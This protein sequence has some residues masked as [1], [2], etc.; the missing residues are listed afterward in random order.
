MRRTLLHG[1]LLAALGLVAVACNAIVGITDVRLRADAGKA[2]ADGG[3]EDPDAAID[4]DSGQPVVRT[5]LLVSGGDG[6]TCAKLKDGPVKC[7]GDNSQGQLGSGADFS[8]V[9]KLPVPVVQLTDANRVCS[10]YKHSCAVR[11]DGTV[12]C[13]GFNLN[14][15]L[16]DGNTSSRSAVPV[17]VDLKAVSQIACGGNFTCAVTRAGGVSCWGGNGSGQLGN[18]T[19]G[20]GSAIPV[21]TK[22]TTAASIAAGEK[23]ACAVLTTGRVAC[24]GANESGQLGTGSTSPELEPRELPPSLPDVAEIAAGQAFTC[25]RTV[26]KGVKCF[27]ANNAGQLGTNSL[28]PTTSS[29]ALTVQGVADAVSIAAGNEHACVA[30]ASGK[31]VCWGSNARG[32]LGNGVIADGG[33]AANPLAVTVVGVT[34]AVTVGAG[35]LHTCAANSATTVKCWGANDLGQIGNDSQTIAYVATTVKSL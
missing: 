20:G 17:V 30:Q 16:G 1:V 35:G 27:G 9:A 11:L 22:L 32:Q 34:D 8:T 4:D 14:G 25:A 2:T 7:W 29:S 5:G 23:H 33:I 15:Q 12:A 19:S 13:W 26:G 6:H 18:G 3:V 24:W 10:G 21:A 28:T 31:V